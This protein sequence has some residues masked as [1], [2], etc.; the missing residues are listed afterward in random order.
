LVPERLGLR[1][2]GLQR[3]PDLLLLEDAGDEGLDLL[4]RDRVALD[5]DEVR[6]EDDGHARFRDQVGGLPRV[7]V[8]DE[9]RLR[10]EA[11]LARDRERERHGRGRVAVEERRDLAL[12][13]AQERLLLVVDLAARDRLEVLDLPRRGS[14]HRAALLVLLLLEVAA[15]E[16]RLAPRGVLAVLLVLDELLQVE[17]QVRERLAKRLGL[18]RARLA[19]LRRGRELDPR[20]GL[21]E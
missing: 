2:E 5:V 1:V 15:L 10:E 9:R 18:R 14:L 4:A 6:P 7:A 21:L 19:A 12:D 8:E 11:V 17:T 3:E 16:E 13:E 20:V